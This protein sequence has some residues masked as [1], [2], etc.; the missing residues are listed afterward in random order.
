MYK[1]KIELLASAN[2]TQVNWNLSWQSIIELSELL[3]KL[4]QK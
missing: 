4:G 3:P 1:N 2:W